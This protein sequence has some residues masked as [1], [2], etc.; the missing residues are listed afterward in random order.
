MDLD[1]IATY[2]TKV[3]GKRVDILLSTKVAS[4]KVGVIKDDNGHSYRIL[5]NATRVTK[6]K[7]VVCVV[8]HEVSHVRTSER[9]DKEFSVEWEK[10]R[11]KFGKHFNV[12]DMESISKELGYGSDVFL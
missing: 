2:C 6:E 10:M 4:D 3:L 8:A 9:H 11:G 5:V 7:E 12:A 1:K